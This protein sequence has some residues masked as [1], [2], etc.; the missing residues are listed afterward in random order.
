VVT[1]EL[2]GRLRLSDGEPAWRRLIEQIPALDEQFRSAKSELPFKHMPRVSFRSA[3]IAGTRWA[4]LASAAGFVDP[5]LSTGF[6]LTLLGVARLA[7]ILAADWQT[8]RFT[9]QLQ[10]YAEHT[11]REL[12]A[13]A[14]LIGS[15]Y[16]S[17]ANFPV[18]SALSLLYFAA[19][20][21]A[22]AARRLG[23][24][25]LASSFLLCEHPE[26]GP[27][28]VDLFDRARR[29]LTLAQSAKLIRDI[30]N[31][32]EPFNVAG[33]GRPERRNWYPVDPQDLLDAAGKLQA[34]EA[35]ISSMLERCGFGT[36]HS[37]ITTEPEPQRELPLD[38][39]N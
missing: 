35:E 19:A 27:A 12:V 17:M 24:P 16:A 29:H 36:R 32:I 22:E 14:R 6:P 31:V 21:Y 33:L 28:C 25:E 39:G 23:K 34:D 26:F 8:E 9:S 2:A 13:T 1:D 15:L 37:A 10:N 20:S 5:L 38:A 7:T 30:N 11:D 4:L 3:Q 18:F